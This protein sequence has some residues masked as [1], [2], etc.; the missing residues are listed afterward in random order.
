MVLPL[1][2]DAAGRKRDADRAIA[3]VEL[4]YGDAAA[5]TIAVFYACRHDT[6]RAIR[7]LTAWTA[8]N[9]GVL[10]DFPNRIDCLQNVASDPR[11]QAL[12]GRIALPES[13]N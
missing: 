3:A 5:G 8:N 10:N 13:Q 6:E 9:T 2:L 4:Q 1:A 7:W 12:K 11:F